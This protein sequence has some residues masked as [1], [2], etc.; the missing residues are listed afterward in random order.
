MVFAY[1]TLMDRH[2]LAIPVELVKFAFGAFI[3]YQTGGWFGLD[4]YF[5]NGTYIVASYMLVSV[6]A[7]VYFN[8]FEKAKTYVRQTASH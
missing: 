7:A 6:L 8:V 4:E 3:L 1:T 2:R 5:A